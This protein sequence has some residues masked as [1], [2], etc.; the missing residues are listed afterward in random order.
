MRGF[1]RLSPR[2]TEAQKA[3]NGPLQAGEPG[4]PVAAHSK[5]PEASEW[6]GG[7]KVPWRAPVAS[8]HS[9]AKELE[10]G[11]QRQKPKGLYKSQEGQA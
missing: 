11:G 8:L 4:N 1:H 9:K 10:S 2:I 3:H 6:E 7:L 5:K